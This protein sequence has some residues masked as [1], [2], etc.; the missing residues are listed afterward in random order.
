MK[1]ECQA[2]ELAYLVFFRETNFSDG[3]FSRA[4]WRHRSHQHPSHDLVRPYNKIKSL[5]R[6][7]DV[8]LLDSSV[9]A[10]YVTV[11]I[12]RDNGYSI[13]LRQLQH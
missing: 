8:N 10:C 6:K 9:T 5:V 4:M 13:V 11:L 1:G 7:F 3:G 2:W 12:S